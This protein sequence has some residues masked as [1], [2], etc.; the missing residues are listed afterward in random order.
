V[1][2]KRL[3]YGETNQQAR[4]TDS[5]HSILL[6]ICLC[7][8]TR[9]GEYP[10]R[11]QTKVHLRKV[12]ILCAV[13]GMRK[14]TTDQTEFLPTLNRCNPLLNNYGIISIAVYYVD[15]LFSPIRKVHKVIEFFVPPGPCIK[16]TEKVI[17]TYWPR[18][19]V[20]EDLEVVAIRQLQFIDFCLLQKRCIC[21]SLG[22]SFNRR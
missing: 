21:N 14:G 5:R 3:L 2:W 10:T 19:P 11:Q 4:E 6:S 1:I 9:V 8:V 17:S 18:K 20:L 22:V 12:L 7:A 15:I 16:S 13:Y